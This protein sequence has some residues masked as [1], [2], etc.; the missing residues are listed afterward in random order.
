MHEQALA[1]IAKLTATIADELRVIWSVTATTRIL[2]RSSP[3]F[4]F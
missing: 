4:E 1:D 2:T 3:R